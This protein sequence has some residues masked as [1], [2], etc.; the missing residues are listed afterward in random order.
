MQIKTVQ[1]QWPTLSGL[2]L[3]TM[4]RSDYYLNNLAHVKHYNRIL[5]SFSVASEIST[6]PCKSVYI[7]DM[8]LLMRHNGTKASGWTDGMH[9]GPWINL[10]Y[11]GLCANALADLGAGMVAGIV[12]PW[13]IPPPPG[14]WSCGRKLQAVVYSVLF[15]SP[16]I[17]LAFCLT[18]PPFHRCVRRGVHRCYMRPWAPSLDQNNIIPII[19]D[20]VTFD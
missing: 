18:R 15:D 7:A 10:Q 5:R 13:V 16:T 9:P 1:K 11:V 2:F 8:A 20:Q 3:R 14:V 4:Y 12:F 17:Q 6:T 19:T